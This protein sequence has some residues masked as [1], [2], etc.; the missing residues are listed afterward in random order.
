[1]YDSLHRADRNGEFALKANFSQL[2]CLGE[3]IENLFKIVTTINAAK[4][5]ICAWCLKCIVIG[6]ISKRSQCLFIF[7]S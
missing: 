7:L 3:A 6:K 2:Q 5:F 1:M 4:M